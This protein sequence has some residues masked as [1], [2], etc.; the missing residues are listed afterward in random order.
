M[1]DVKREAPVSGC[2][3]RSIDVSAESLS[4]YIYITSGSKEDSAVALFSQSLSLNFL[5]AKVLPTKLL[6]ER[7]ELS[8]RTCLQ[9]AG[10]MRNP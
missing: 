4:T 10:L 2:Y 9:Q 3:V 5:F 1:R 8:F 7:R 6:C